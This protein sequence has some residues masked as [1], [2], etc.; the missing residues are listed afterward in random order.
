MLRDTLLLHLLKSGLATNM[1]CGC[2]AKLK[3]ELDPIKHLVGVWTDGKRGCNIPSLLLFMKKPGIDYE[4]SFS[5][6]YPAQM[7]KRG[8]ISLLLLLSIQVKE[9]RGRLK[10]LS[11]TI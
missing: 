11:M 4:A 5:G 6:L 3:L 1:N 2:N 8:A 7:V 10:S 9:K